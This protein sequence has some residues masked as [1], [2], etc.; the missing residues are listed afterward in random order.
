MNYIIFVIPKRRYQQ[1]PLLLWKNYKE[2]F[3]WEDFYNIPM[4]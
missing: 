1:L 4:E 3:P 2:T